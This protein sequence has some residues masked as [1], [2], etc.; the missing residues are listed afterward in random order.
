MMGLHFMGDVPFRDVYIHPL[1]RDEKGRKMSKS[2]GIGVDP[3]DLAA[4]HGTDALRWTLTSLAAQGRDIRFGVSQLEGGRTFVTKLWNAARFALMNLGDFDAAAKPPARESRPL[5][6]RWILTRLD[7]AL[8]GAHA[9]LEGYRFNDAASTLY[10]FVWGELCDWYIELAKPA[11]QRGEPAVKAATQRTLLEALE[12]ALLGLH[13]VMPF[14]TE[15]IFAALPGHDGRTLLE[16]RYP[17]PGPALGEDEARSMEGLL[18]IVS[19][20]RQV[21]GELGLPPA[22]RVRLVLPP[23]ARD[24]VEQHAA[25]LRT[26]TGAFD[27]AFDDGEPP[28]HAALTRA[29]G[30]PVRV[31]VGDPAFL[32]DEARRLEKALQT[33]EKD[34]AFVSKKLENPDF[35]KRAKEEVVAAEREK[36]S[37]LEAERS[38]LRE[39]LERIGKLA[40]PG[41]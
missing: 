14:V 30:F 17:E 5:Y 24:L 41:A 16:R 2:K 39:R 22:L 25:G 18:E 32:A 29:A 13:P 33:L 21:R 36:H 38:A 27:L 9:A 19:R 12:G 1:V 20:V 28:A 37:R 40:G 4:A 35:V 3:M 10:H 26:L 8:A 23:G 15:E 11:L 31:E 34:L 6:D 7:A